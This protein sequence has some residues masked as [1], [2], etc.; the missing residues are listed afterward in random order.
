MDYI[1]KILAVNLQKRIKLCQTIC[2]T[3]QYWSCPQ[4]HRK[5]TRLKEKCQSINS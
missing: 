1:D 5:R 4:I 2:N 3:L